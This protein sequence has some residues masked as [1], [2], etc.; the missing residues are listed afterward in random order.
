M[1]KVNVV[2]PPERRSVPMESGLS[3]I[4]A[5]STVTK[6][7]MSPSPMSFALIVVEIVASAEE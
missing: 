3:E 6:T 2:F 4:W 7:P 5:G 1:S